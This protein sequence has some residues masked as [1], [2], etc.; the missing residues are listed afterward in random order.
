MF[1]RFEVQ[2]STDRFRVHDRS[3]IRLAIGEANEL[4]RHLQDGEVIRQADGCARARGDGDLLPAN[5]DRAD[6]LGDKPEVVAGI[7]R[8]RGAERLAADCY[9]ADFRDDADPISRARTAD[10]RIIA[11]SKVAW[12]GR[13]N[14]GNNAAG[15]PV[16]A[17]GH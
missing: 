12:S 3:E 17:H 14:A 1:E 5:V 8:D 10:L 4:Q 15:N 9:A 7:V 11:C 6:L 2:S 16:A 13:L